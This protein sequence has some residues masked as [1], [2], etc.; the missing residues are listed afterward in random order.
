MKAALKL[1]MTVT[2]LLLIAVSVGLV[3]LITRFE[4]VLR[5]G[6]TH[7]AGQILQAEVRLEAVRLDWAEQALLFKGVSVYNPGGFTDREA[8]RIETLRVR[9]NLLTVFARTP[10]IQ[11][12][13][14]G[15]ASLH[16]QH[17]R[18]SGTNLGAMLEHARAWTG[19]QED[20]E[21]RIWGR[22]MKVAA[23]RAGP[24]SLNVRPVDGPEQNLALDAFAEPEPAGDEMVTGARVM[25]LILHALIRKL[26]AAETLP[27]SV[28]EVVMEE[29]ARDFAGEA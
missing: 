10:E 16:L 5:S 22:R 17:Q 4:G 15:A 8:L 18:G 12:I 21:R 26:A 2:G 29:A 19:Q 13:S 23:L 6:L 28:R 3:L 14:L 9:P 24:A 27:A 20:G 11:D 1:I 7:Q 25:H